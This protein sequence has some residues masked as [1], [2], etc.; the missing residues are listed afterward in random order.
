MFFF[1]LALVLLLALLASV[2]FTAGRLRG[3]LW[4]GAMWFF[5]LLLLGTWALAIW[6]LP[7]GPTVSG[8][9]LAPYVI[10]AVM[11]CVLLAAVTTAGRR[12]SDDA[13]SEGARRV[14][15]RVTARA[16][17][18]AAILVLATAIAIHY[19]TTA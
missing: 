4:P 18:W 16:F 6:L 19:L 10:A 5:S 15:I 13:G 8:T 7:V 9:R 12:S 1:E 11:I 14:A 2:A 17:F 3:S